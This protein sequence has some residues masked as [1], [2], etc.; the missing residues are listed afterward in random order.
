MGVGFGKSEVAAGGARWRGDYCRDLDIWGTK[1]CFQDNG[2]VVLKGAEEDGG[3]RLHRCIILAI[4]RLGFVLV[5]CGL[6]GRRS[7]SA[8]GYYQQ[9]N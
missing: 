4:D 1:K 3:N 5:E 7:T 6:Y 2:G 9:G 8:W